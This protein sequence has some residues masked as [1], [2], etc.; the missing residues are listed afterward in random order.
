MIRFV[1]AIDEKLGI[2]DDEGIPWN[3]PTDK[4]YFV[5]QTRNG[6][7]LMGFDTYLEFKKPMHK[8]PNYVASRSKKEL[9]PGFVL[10]N[11]VPA[12]Y[13]EHKGEIINN[14]GGAG[15]FT[16]TLK[17]ADEL[18]LTLVHGDFNCTKFFPAYEKDFELVNKA[19]P[20][21]ENGITFHYENWKRKR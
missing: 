2:A 17:Y 6:L 4:K 18:V 13:E 1:A 12:F 9:K 14:I 19:E 20:I 10:V 5:N 7:I 21:I 3:L 11:D 8:A 16:S 15:L